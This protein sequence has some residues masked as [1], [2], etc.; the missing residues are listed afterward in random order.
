MEAK[1]SSKGNT[2][3]A[4]MYQT[5]SYVSKLSSK[6]SCTSSD[7]DNA[8]HCLLRRLAA[9]YLLRGLATPYLLRRLAAPY[10]LR[11]LATS[12]LLRRHYSLVISSGPE[13]AF[14]TSAIPVDHSNME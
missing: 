2:S 10:L 7:G 9:P 6:G 5:L 11:G 13:V 3:I 14:V 1:L 12:Y 4:S 8:A